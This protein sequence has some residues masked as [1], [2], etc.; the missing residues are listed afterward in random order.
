MVQTYQFIPGSVLHNEFDEGVSGLASDGPRSRVVTDDVHNARYLL[1]VLLDQL[2]ASLLISDDLESMLKKIS[3]SLW[4]IM[5]EFLSLA[6]FCRPCL[7]CV[8]KDRSLS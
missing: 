7:I 1:T 6:N 2:G 8:C 4:P 5:P 3:S